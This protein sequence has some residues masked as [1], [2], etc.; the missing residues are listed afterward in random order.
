LEDFPNAKTS[1]KSV[2]SVASVARRFGVNVPKRPQV[3]NVEELKL[4]L[5]IAEARIA[6]L[7]AQMADLEAYVGIEVQEEAA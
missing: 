3:N 4:S 5:E 2:A 6:E 7:E 1:A